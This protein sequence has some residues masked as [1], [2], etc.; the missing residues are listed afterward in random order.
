MIAKNSLLHLGYRALAVA[1]TQNQA[2]GKGGS[3]DL[4]NVF[5]TAS[6]ESLLLQQVALPGGVAEAAS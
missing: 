3:A 1:I 4:G 6:N 5:R 2:F